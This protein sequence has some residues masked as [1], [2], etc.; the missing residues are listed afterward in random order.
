MD[1]S[2][3]EFENNFGMLFVADEKPYSG[4]NIWKIIGFLYYFAPVD[5]KKS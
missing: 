4:T 1:Y 5:L 3:S 2:T